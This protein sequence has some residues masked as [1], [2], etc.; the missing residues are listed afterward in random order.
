MLTK[1]FMQRL[2]LDEGQ[3]R[4]G[5]RHVVYDDHTG[6]AL[7]KGD[8]LEGYP[9]VGY[10]INLQVGIPD[11]SAGYLL[12]IAAG[13]IERELIMKLE[14]YCELDQ[15]RREALLNMAY[16]MGVTGLL[17]F[18]N[19]IEHL[20]NRRYKEAANEA[21]NSKW[22][23]QVNKRADRMCKQLETGIRQN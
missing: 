7:K 16:N 4:S 21:M 12:T 17:K 15:V 8:T 10:G 22:S 23:G 13:A 18:E 2:E 6:K 3:V 11:I 19:M 20:K 9:T 1:E 14:V 5:G